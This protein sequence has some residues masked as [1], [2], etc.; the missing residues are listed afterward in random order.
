MD[1]SCVCEVCMHLH[2]Y[3]HMCS[4][5]A[6]VCSSFKAYVYG[7]ILQAFLKILCLNV[8]MILLCMPFLLVRVQ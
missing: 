4:M 3:L 8:R 2:A 5:Y 1:G 6:D 7:I